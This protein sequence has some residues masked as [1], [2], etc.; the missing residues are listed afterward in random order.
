MA[1][2]PDARIHEIIVLVLIPRVVDDDG[3]DKAGKRTHS[4]NPR[5]RSK[6]RREEK[7]DQKGRH[8]LQAHAVL[9]GRKVGQRTVVGERNEQAKRHYREGDHLAYKRDSCVRS[10]LHVRVHNLRHHHVRG[11]NQQRVGGRN[12][13]SNGAHKNQQTRHVAEAARTHQLGNNASERV[14]GLLALEQIHAQRAR[15]DTDKHGQPRRERDHEVRKLHRLKFARG[16]GALLEVRQR[17]E[18]DP[19]QRETPHCH[20]VLR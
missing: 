16:V 13:G 11:G 6:P 5:V 12:D 2:A 10:V 20:L 17:G 19:L 4:N 15:E 1:Q 9:H 7:A 14:R 18:R 3:G 8:G